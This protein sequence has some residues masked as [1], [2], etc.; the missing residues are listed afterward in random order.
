MTASKDIK[1]YH[2]RRRANN[3][4]IFNTIKLLTSDVWEKFQQMF[5]ETGFNV[6][7]HC[8][9]VELEVFRI[10]EAEKVLEN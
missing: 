1:F 3:V 8:K 9:L 4:G 10:T 6:Y 2:C 7:I 5:D